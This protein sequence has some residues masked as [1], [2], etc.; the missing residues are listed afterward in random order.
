[1]RPLLTATLAAAV[2]AGAGC[3]GK[4]DPVGGGSALDQPPHSA[5][6]C[7]GLDNDMD[8]LIDEDFRDDRGRYVGVDHCGGCDRPCAGTVE[9]A[10]EEACGLVGGVPTCTAAACEPGWE[11]GPGGRCV[12]WDARLCLPCLLDGDCGGFERAVCARIAGEDR[13][14]VTCTGACPG[15]YACREG[16]CVPVGGSCRCEPG[17]E[18]ELACAIDLP[19]EEDPCVGHAFCDDG[20]MGPCLGSEEICDGRD[21]DCDTEV[22][23][24]FRNEVGGYDDI[25]NCGQCG[26]DCTADI[27]PYG[28]LDCGGDPFAPMCH[29]LCEDELDGR[30]VGDEVDADLVISNGCECTI[31]TS[32]DPAGPAQAYGQDLDTN[33]DGADGIVTRSY[34]V[35][36]DGDDGWAGSPLRPLLTLD[37]AVRRAHESLATD[38]P[39]P[40]VFVVSGTYIE[41]VTIPDGVSV[42]GG[43]RNDFLGLDP[44]GYI[45]QLV[46]ADPAAAPGGA[47]LVV[48][49]AGTRSTVVEGLHVRGADAP[50][51]GEPAF[52][53]YVR[54][55][56][57]ALVLRD[58]TIRSGR[59]G[60]GADGTHGRAGTTPAV[61]P[62]AGDPIRASTEDDAHQC[63]RG[64]SNRVQG[65]QGG[66]N[67]C[68]GRNVSGGAGGTAVCPVFGS[69]QEQGR[70]GRSGGGTAYG[71]TGGTGGLDSE[72]PIT[73][74]CPTWLCC[75][76]SDFTVPSDYRI[77][78][79]GRNGRD[80]EPG[81]AG[82]GCHEPMGSLAGGEWTPVAATAGTHGGPGGG[83]G[84][85]GA[86]GGTAITWYDE[87]C[88]LPDG[89]GGG[90][91]GGG[92][93]GCGGAGGTPGTSG[94]PSV[95][96]VIEFVRGP[97][98][99]SVVPLPAFESL[100][101]IAGEGGEGGTGG[102]GGS[103]GIGG[104]GAPGG[105][106]DWTLRTTLTLSAPTKGGHGGQGGTGG[107][108]GGAGGGCG[109]TSAAV[110][111][112]LDGGADPGYSAALGATSVLTAGLP[113][114]GGSGGGGAV[115][116]GDGRDGEATDVVID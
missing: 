55:P 95:G 63:I 64:S 68:D 82:S 101:V 54:N 15:G 19:G 5:E 74:S 93:G 58:L 36:P 44:D 33:C 10:A 11:P 43:Y 17:D 14:S 7:D 73:T 34:Y 115:P 29:L 114:H 90:G 24:D 53:V 106:L 100:T 50:D 104:A 99:P 92:A 60:S 48:D 72:G 47:A 6:V 103:G 46:A 32:D 13:C 9:H 69:Q 111:V 79:D 78:G 21:N 87:E 85:G 108:G 51:A 41:T 18:F 109:G 57:A 16:R 8:G 76:L 107:S 86:G 35:A 70:S 113:G 40:D 42:H 102:A 110:W 66:T 23:E 84:G 49:D 30:D 80:G 20:V 88:E 71:G 27:V 4:T 65:G 22:D 38:L 39:R 67:T 94:A 52:G 45:T 112:V 89:L 25:H 31:T 81:T 37:E 105:D 98:S 75:G 97:G 26:V 59:A 12:P 1:M 3:G 116:G 83:G 77:A 56:G 2:A 28:D 61:D 91:G 62:T 96:L